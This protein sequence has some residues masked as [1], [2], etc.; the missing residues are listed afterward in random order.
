MIITR[1]LEEWRSGNILGSLYRVRDDKI[2][3]S[4]GAG[5]LGGKG[6]VTCVHAPHGLVFL[7]TFHRRGRTG[8]GENRFI[9]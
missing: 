6:E 8:G 2:P 1:R 5:W 7:G 4:L 3:I 9:E